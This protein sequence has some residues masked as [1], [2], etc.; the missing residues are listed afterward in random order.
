MSLF[1]CPFCGPRGLEEFAFHKTLPNAGDDAY[2]S[3]FERHNDPVESLEHWQHR[4]GCRA[5]L[6]VHRNP[7]TGAVLQVTGLYGEIP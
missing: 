2:S 6:Q 3:T 5:W 1:R 4:A 7:T